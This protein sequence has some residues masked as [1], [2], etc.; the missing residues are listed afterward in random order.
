MLQFKFVCVVV[1]VGVC[2][3]VNFVGFKL[4]SIFKFH[5]KKKKKEIKKKIKTHPKI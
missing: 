4:L 3:C 5:L 2:V 1:V